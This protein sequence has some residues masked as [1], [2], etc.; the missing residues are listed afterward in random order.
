VARKAVQ[1]SNVSMVA[2]G[3]RGKLFV[4]TCSS[5]PDAP[6]ERTG[7]IGLEVRAVRLRPALAANFVS[8]PTQF[9]RM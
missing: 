1:R 3:Q 6:E 4:G 2:L 5:V 7:M 8:E 9:G